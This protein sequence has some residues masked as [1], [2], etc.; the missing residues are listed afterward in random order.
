VCGFR[1]GH[2]QQ[3]SAETTP[4]LSLV[5]PQMHKYTAASPGVAAKR[6]DDFA[7]LTSQPTSQKL[8]IEVSS[9]LDIELIDALNEECVKLP[10]FV[11]ITELDDGRINGT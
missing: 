9:R 10:T 5:H 11:V 4:T 1:L 2:L 6:G 7:L 8:S 3:R